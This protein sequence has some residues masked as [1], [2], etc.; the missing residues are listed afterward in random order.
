MTFYG[1]DD[2]LS[3]VEYVCVVTFHDMLMT[4]HDVNDKCVMMLMTSALMT[5]ASHIHR[6]YGAM[7]RRK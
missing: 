6:C 2:V 3:E 4:F 1:I 5:S 7:P